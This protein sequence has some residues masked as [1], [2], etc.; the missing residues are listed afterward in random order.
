MKSSRSQQSNVNNLCVCEWALNIHW[1]QILNRW[2]IHHLL[3]HRAVKVT[4]PS[5]PSQ[6]WNVTWLEPVFHD[7]INVLC[8]SDMKQ[9]PPQVSNCVASPYVC[10]SDVNSPGNCC[11]HPQPEKQQWTGGISWPVLGRLLLCHQWTLVC[12]GASVHKGRSY[13]HTFTCWTSDSCSSL[14]MC[15]TQRF[16]TLKVKNDEETLKK[17]MSQITSILH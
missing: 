15:H 8:W 3:N 9:N 12:T 10:A 14:W 4:T 13:T 7:S 1:F 17:S 16:T 11:L 2:F 6:C 5:V